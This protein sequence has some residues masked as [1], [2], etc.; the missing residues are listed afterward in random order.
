MTLETFPG[1][2]DKLSSF[3]AIL[4]LDADD[5]AISAAVAEAELPALL[6]TLA[7][8]TGDQALLAPDLVPPTPPM[9]T[10]IAPQGGMSPQAQARARALA[11]AAI[12]RAREHG[13]PRA[14]PTIEA[15]QASIAFIT[16]GAAADYLGLLMHEIGLPADAGRPNWTKAEIAPARAF[17][18]AVIG[19][20]LSGIAT[21][22][23][24]S[25]AGLDFT[26][27]EKNP[28]IGGIWWNNIYPGCRLDTPNFA[29]SYSFAQK[30][31]WPQQFSERSEILAYA[32]R[33]V[34]EAGLRRHFAFSTE[35]MSMRYDEVRGG[36]WL[37]TRRDG[38][39][40]TEFAHVVIPAVGHLNRPNIPDLPGREVFGGEA[41]HSSEWPVGCEVDGKR[42]A[43]IGTGASGFQ[44]VPS[45]VGSVRSMHVFQRNP[46]W[47]LPTP[48]YH[49]DIKPGMAWLLARVPYYGRWFRFWQFWIAAEGR[50]PAVKVDPDWRHPVSIS[51]IN[52][53]LRQGCLEILSAQVGDR[54]DLFEKLTPAYPPGA[55]RMVRDNGAYVE[56]LKKPHVELVTERIERLTATGIVTADGAHREVDMI[57]HATGFLASDYL[58]PI[59]IEGRDGVKLHEFWNGDCRA[60]LGTTV[61]GF[62]NL[63][64]NGGPN[65]GLVVN[66]SALFIAE[67]A[68]E[69]S[70]RAI[71]YMLRHAVRAAEVRTE[72][73]DTFNA[74]VDFHNTL[75]AWGTTKVNTWYQN[76]NG[77]PTVTWPHPILEY[78]RRTSVFEPADYFF[79]PTD[80]RTNR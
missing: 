30:A 78:F 23:R 55:K 76:R 3:E 61:P 2:T 66:G 75:R 22:Y 79:E 54:R 17:R 36:W 57:V 39:D 13:W 21:A 41:F 16:K 42:V 49:D 24:L 35:I 63:F 28:D 65:S 58:D 59:V 15:L 68:L 52:E 9:I 26:V 27:F 31:D 11:T 7:T 48:T 80:T 71:E 56:A 18:V 47:M 43:V 46:A 29:Y 44:I 33:V 34:E 60:Y 53:E 25:Q 77:R 67:C 73:Y 4:P 45:I 20:G 12:V 6:A 8:L 37:R 1:G 51:A 50:F 70:L 74:D 40:G 72:P 5:E 38:R 69:Y 19:G 62:P 64:I 14:E 10:R 32:M